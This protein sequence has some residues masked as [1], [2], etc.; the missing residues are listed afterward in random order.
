MPSL[1]LFEPWNRFEPEPLAKEANT[2]VP[3]VPQPLLPKSHFLIIYILVKF[4]QIGSQ[5]WTN[6]AAATPQ[7]FCSRNFSRLEPSIESRR[8]GANSSKLSVQNIVTA[9]MFWTTGPRPT[10]GFQF[11]SR[12]GEDL[13]DGSF[14]NED[15]GR[16]RL[17]FD[18]DRSGWRLRFGNDS[19][20]W[21]QVNNTF[22]PC[23]R[24]GGLA[25]IFTFLFN[26]K[27]LAKVNKLI[28]LGDAFF[29]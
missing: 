22:N 13:L 15:Y 11:D 19:S 7:T 20:R 18:N 14:R 21:I 5:W 4:S 26:Q 23:T 2:L 17:D 9:C 8:P 12:F 25:L 29:N 1:Y 3:T 16:F 27:I 6:E 24:Y 28:L 10:W